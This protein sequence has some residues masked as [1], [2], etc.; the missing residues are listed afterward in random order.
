MISTHTEVWHA[1]IYLKLNLVHSP[2]PSGYFV[3]IINS[4]STLL[5]WPIVGLLILFILFGNV[6]FIM[7][8][9]YSLCFTGST[10]WSVSYYNCIYIWSYYIVIHFT[11]LVMLKG[12]ILYHPKGVTYHPRSKV[13]RLTMLS[14]SGKHLAYYLPYITLSHRRLSLF[15]FWTI[16]SL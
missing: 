7:V 11:S 15:L 9:H 5:K 8:H 13:N 16:N 1:I 2:G 14:I 4:Y 10:C 6:F 12:L 3:C